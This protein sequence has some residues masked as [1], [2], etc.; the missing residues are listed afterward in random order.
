MFDA[1]ETSPTPCPG[2]VERRSVED[3]GNQGGT[4][5]LSAGLLS[6]GLLRAGLLSAGLLRAGPI[7][8]TLGAAHLDLSL[9][10]GEV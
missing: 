1:T 6:A 9:S 10:V 3:A 5:L 7:T 4:L 8:L 2:G